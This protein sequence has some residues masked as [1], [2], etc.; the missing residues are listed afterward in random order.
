M[1]LFEKLLLTGFVISLHWPNLAHA[2]SQVEYH[3]T[4]PY[5]PPPVTLTYTGQVERNEVYFMPASPENDGLTGISP[6]S[7][8]YFASIFN[9]QA[10]VDFGRPLGVIVLTPVFPRPALDTA[11]DNLYVHALSRESMLAREPSLHRIDLQLLA[12]AKDLPRVACSTSITSSSTASHTRT[13]RLSL[14][15]GI[16]SSR[17]WTSRRLHCPGRNLTTDPKWLCDRVSQT[18]EN[19]L[20][21][22]ESK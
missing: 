16:F 22:E 14:W 3:L 8:A 1:S 17:Y 20:Q 4:Q 18:A 10:G 9:E 2:E 15:C 5:G 19:G 13:V 12:M 21:A 6:E 7:R 11:E